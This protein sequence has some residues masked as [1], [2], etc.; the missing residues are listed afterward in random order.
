MPSL[1]P[2]VPFNAICRVIP[3]IFIALLL[4]E[5]IPLIAIYAPFMLPSTCILP[6]Q[7]ARIEAA[8]TEKAIVFANNYRPLFA[9]LKLKEDPAGHL[10]TNL[11]KEDEVSFAICGLVESYAYA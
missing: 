8:K 4:E 3:F 7:R 11:L 5:V 1:P 9:Q 6:S 2:S 10:S